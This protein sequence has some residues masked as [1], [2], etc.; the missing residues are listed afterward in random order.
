M[1]ETLNWRQ[2][3]GKII[4]DTQERQRIANV[5]EVNPITLTRWAGDK[6]NPRLESARLLLDALPEHAAQLRVL[7]AHEFPEFASLLPHAAQEPQS[8]PS[9]FYA[10]VLKA[11]AEALPILR[12]S[13]ISILVLQQML[14]HLDP[15]QLGLLVL[16]AQCSPPPSGQKVRSLRLIYGRG[17]APWN[18]HQMLNTHFIG[19]EALMGQALLSGRLLVAHYHDDLL[20]L[21]STRSDSRVESALA[22]PLLRSDTTPGCLYLAST[23]PDFFPLP[24]QD[25]IQAYAD[26][27]VIAFDPDEF[28]ALSDLA[29]GVFPSHHVQQ[30]YLAQF[31]ERVKRRMIEALHQGQ[32][33]TRPQAELQVWQELEEELLRVEFAL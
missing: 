30:R 15:H 19:A 33:L 27:L 10:R 14:V 11:N 5:L 12:A 4:N 21:H 29:F 28:Y 31:Q 23:L 9:E 25:V 20:N 18:T 26:L 2:L 22:C 17:T 8:I 24:L 7:I 13:S 16:V 1:E 32:V 6:S 3:L